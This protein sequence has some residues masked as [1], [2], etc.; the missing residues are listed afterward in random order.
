[1]TAP[2]PE[3]AAEVVVNLTGW[4]RARADEVVAALGLRWVGWHE[5]GGTDDPGVPMWVL[6]GPETRVVGA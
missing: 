4:D 6:D 3:L 1:M 5:F 2:D